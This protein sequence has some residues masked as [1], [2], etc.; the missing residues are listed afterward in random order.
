MVSIVVKGKLS[1]TVNAFCKV[2]TNTRM[3]CNSGGNGDA[4]EPV[5]AEEAEE[6]VE[7][8]EAEDGDCC[9]DCGD[10]PDEAKRLVR[11]S[12]GLSMDATC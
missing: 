7:A 11:G 5:E 12:L 2:S 3:G 1:R 8:V 6:A 9:V 10:E 4:E